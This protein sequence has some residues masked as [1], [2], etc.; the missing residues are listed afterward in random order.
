LKNNKTEGT[1]IDSLQMLKNLSR[2][3]N[4]ECCIMLAGMFRSSK[5]ITYCGNGEWYIFNEIDDSDM[6]FHSDKQLAEEY[7]LLIEA[8]EKNALIRYPWSE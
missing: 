4:M 3:K 8:I 7:P 6:E 5:I 1:I 2:N